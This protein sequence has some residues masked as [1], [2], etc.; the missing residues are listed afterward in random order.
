MNHCRTSETRLHCSAWLPGGAVRGGVVPGG[1]GYGGWCVPWY[2]PV[3][4]VRVMVLHCFP[5]FLHCGSTGTRLWPHWDPFVA[6]LGPVCGL[7]LPHFP[8][9]LAW[10]S[11]LFG[12]FF[13]N[14]DTFFVNFRKFTHFRCV[15]VVS[16]PW[17]LNPYPIPGAFVKMSQKCLKITIFSMFLSAQN[18]Y[19]ILGEMTKITVFREND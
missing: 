7:I 1:S 3:V 11:T 16:V 9:V 10:F 2:P 13:V 12:H 17:C 6:S 18:P 5:L 8:L 4:W 14:F 19:P 15:S